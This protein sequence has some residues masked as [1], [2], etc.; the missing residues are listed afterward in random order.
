MLTEDEIPRLFQN[1]QRATR[2]EGGTQSGWG[3]ELTVV[4]GVVEAHKG[5]IRV[6]SSEG[7]GTRFLLEIPRAVAKSIDA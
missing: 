7:K 5:K 2:A 6:E 3:L 1:F 4:K